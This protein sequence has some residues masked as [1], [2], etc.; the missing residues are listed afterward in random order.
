[1]T[2]PSAAGQGPLVSL[3][4]CTFNRRAVLGDAL[5]CA[6]RQ[7]HRNLQIIVINDGGPDVADL[8]AACNDG[9]I[10]LVQNPHNRGKAACLN[11]ALELARGKYVAYLDDDDLLYPDHVASLAGALEASADCGVAFSDLYRTMSRTGSDGK[12]VALGKYLEIMRDFDRE[13]LF[14]FNHVLHVSLMHRRDLIEKTGP[15]N[16]NVK[17]LIDWDMTRRLAF[18]SDFLHVR[19]VTGEYAIP[20]TASDRISHQMRKDKN[21]YDRYVR[22][23]RTTRPAKPWPK[24]KDLSIFFLPHRMD[25]QAADS[26]G[27]IWKHTFVPYQVYLPLPPEQLDS[28]DTADMPNLIRVPISA[29]APLTARV[30]ACLE[31]C[32]GECVALVTPGAQVKDL[33][34]ESARHAL[35]HNPHPAVGYLLEGP[36]EAEIPLAVVWK[37]G[38]RS[39][40]RA[41]PA[42]NAR[43]SLREAGISLVAP[44][45]AECPFAFDGILR[46][47]DDVA[48]EG[49][50]AKAAELF[51]KLPGKF[52]NDLWMMEKRA[53]ALHHTGA[54]AEE[55]LR[56]CVEINRQRPS[57]ESLL[58]EARLR[59]ERDQLPQAVELLESARRQLVWKGGT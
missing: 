18:F 46:T 10:V 44:T 36:Q 5:A 30:D 54:G 34:V 21:E 39:A 37:D 15:Y 35:I 56:L 45:L 51:D 29:E 28:L 49:N 33:W 19:R 3:I 47:A 41:T 40:R 27:R 24:V 53:M 14:Y 52:A 25:L 26:L 43:E 31:R 48:A 8:V 38:L 57:V 12:R 23:I 11:Q 32:E 59:R 7:T 17:V 4:T 13:F 58:L 22:T 2:S 6:V 16:E 42:L 1:M 55:A 20:E 9:R 50:W